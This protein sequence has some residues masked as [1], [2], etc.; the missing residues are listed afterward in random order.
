MEK[1]TAAKHSLPRL[2]SRLDRLVSKERLAL[3]R[4][5]NACGDE[6]VMAAAMEEIVQP[7]LFKLQQTALSHAPD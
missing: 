6:D 3:V 7:Y 1:T 2:R 4:G 5:D